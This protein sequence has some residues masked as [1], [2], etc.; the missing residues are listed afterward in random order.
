MSGIRFC[1]PID[2]EGHW[3]TLSQLLTQSVDG[4]FFLGGE[5]AVTLPGN[6][7]NGSQEV[8]L[9][10]RETSWWKT[11]L[12]VL[13]YMTV[14]IPVIMLIAKAV[15]RSYYRFHSCGLN[16]PVHYG[17]IIHNG[18][19][20]P[21]LYNGPLP[22]ARAPLT[23]VRSS[24]GPTDLKVSVLYN[25]KFRPHGPIVPKPTDIKTE[26]TVSKYSWN[27]QTQND[28]TLKVEEGRIN[29]IWWEAMRQGAITGVDA[30]QAACVKREDLKGF[31]EGALQK[32][33]VHQNELEAFTQYWKGLLGEGD[34]PYLLVQLVQPSEVQNYVPEM[35][36]EGEQAPLFDLNRFYF[37]FESAPD[38]SRGMEPELYLNNLENVELGPNTVI[39][40]GGEVVNDVA[41]DWEPSFNE[42]FVRRY[43]YA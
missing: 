1:T 8:V 42:E 40:L 29:M 10:Q 43:I 2:Y 22:M 19:N 9:Q 27:V 30:T 26:G 38:A 15:L 39:D 21:V 18:P 4:Y 35:Q 14:I 11:A 28:G 23:L 32:R 7:R 12:K 13:S 20:G 36:V 25:E 33:G 16:E 3:A 17:P 24:L 6:V 37:R 41:R 5:V 34:S 31:L